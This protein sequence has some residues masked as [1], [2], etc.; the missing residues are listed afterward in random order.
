MT[1]AVLR[2]ARA[3]SAAALLSVCVFLIVSRVTLAPKH[4]FYFDSINFAL[5][6]Q[7]FN[8]ALHQPQPPGY[9]LFVAVTKVVHHLTSS[10]RDTFLVTGI[11]A[12]AAALGA[13]WLL[14][15]EL[16]GARAADLSGL[17]LLVHPPFWLAC[18]T[19]QVRIFLALG[20]AVLMVAAWRSVSEEGCRWF[21]ASAFLLGAASGFRP[22]MLLFGLPLIIFAGAAQRRPV[23]H[24][25]FA[26]LAGLAAV[27]GWVAVVV[28]AS[29][30]LPQYIQLVAD[31]ARTQFSGSSLA[32]GA[33]SKAAYRMLK[34]AVIWYGLPAAAWL[35]MLPLAK[36]IRAD[37]QRIGAFFLV[38]C[39]PSFLFHAIIHVGDPDHTLFAAPAICAVG[40]AVLARLKHTGLAI[41]AVVVS[42][43]LFLLPLK[44]IARAFTYQAVQEIDS[45][46]C[47][48]FEAI[49]ELAGTGPV[50]LVTY[51]HRIPY[52]NF[53][54][55]F[56][57]LDVVVLHDSPMGPAM[58]EPTAWIIRNRSTK[59][60]R[61][62]I[63]VAPKTK[64][65]W[66]LSRGQGMHKLL[67]KSVPLAQ[68]RNLSYITETTTT[69]DF[70]FG[71]YL[72]ANA[73]TGLLS[74]R[75]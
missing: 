39:L 38:A 48:T 40:G 4:L 35:C 9:P 59:V 19:N 20:A 55:Y 30:G 54:Y 71:P 8:P 34:M 51:D 1:T 5:A 63:V 69:P 50:A 70:Y 67:N 44:G 41:A 26:M 15:Y 6:L 31:Y 17:L 7:E 74:D 13:V 62:K 57:N 24:W 3:G 25:G 27:T 68:H 33:T 64:I 61:G 12:S 28:H 56:P 18:L 73:G 46:T 65:V 47:E 53:S 29:G 45:L 52:R 36:G 21:V 11:L 75:L 22:E 43:S 23:R 32:F 10:D 16:F 37:L 42:C 66:L 58:P 2:S 60:S 14:A 49:Q 72:F